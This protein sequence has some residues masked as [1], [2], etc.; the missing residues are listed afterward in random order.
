M[1]YDLPQEVLEGLKQARKRDLFR[2]NRLRVHIGDAV[3]PVARLWEDGFSLE[4]EAAPHLRGLVDIYDGGRHLY[5]CLIVC[6]EIEG[7]ERVFEFKRHTA[8]SDEAPVDFWKD[9]NAP[10]ALLS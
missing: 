3:Y 4:A 9:E 1:I 2:R 7:D 8:V 5:Q 10:V 6:S